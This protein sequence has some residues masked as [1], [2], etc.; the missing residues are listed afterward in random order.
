MVVLLK[1]TNYIK[2]LFRGKN[3]RSGIGHTVKGTV[4]CRQGR[5]QKVSE[6]FK[7]RDIRLTRGRDLTYLKPRSLMFVFF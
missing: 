2:L 1:L 6:G 5:N 4:D 3:K 7:L